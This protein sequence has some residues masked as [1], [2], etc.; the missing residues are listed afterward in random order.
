MHLERTGHHDSLQLVTPLI[1]LQVELMWSIITASMP[2]FKHI[3]LTHM[4][5]HDGLPFAASRLEEAR[6]RPAQLKPR[7]FSGAHAI[8]ASWRTD[9]IELRNVIRA[10]RP[11]STVI[12][13][14]AGVSTTR[15]LERDLEDGVR[16]QVE[17]EVRHEP[18]NFEQDLAPLAEDD[19]ETFVLGD[20]SSVDEHDVEG[21]D[22]VV[23][24]RYERTDEVRF[25][26]I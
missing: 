20:K 1:W 5:I 13:S 12:V 4:R 23:C 15:G 7:P 11:S 14:A 2:P 26:N 16:C 25:I 3:F 8:P 18:V 9:P 6:P 24:I 19:V 10:T 17:W 22:D 21:Q